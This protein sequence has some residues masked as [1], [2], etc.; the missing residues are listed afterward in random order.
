[1]TR[2]AELASAKR[3]GVRMAATEMAAEGN[4]SPAP[5]SRLQEARGNGRTSGVGRPRLC[6]AELD[7]I[8]SRDRQDTRAGDEQKNGDRAMSGKPGQGPKKSLTEQLAALGNIRPRRLRTR[9]TRRSRPLLLP[10]NIPTSTLQP[11]PSVSSRSCWTCAFLN[12]NRLALGYS[13][14]VSL[15]PS[16]VPRALQLDF[17]GHR[18]TVKAATFCRC[19]GGIF[20]FTRSAGSAR[21]TLG[22][23]PTARNAPYSRFDHRKNSGRTRNAIIL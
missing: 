2:R 5:K 22:S 21:L 15:F 18:V 6:R 12:G 10:R 23:S 20:W 3:S 19:S 13:Y 11:P 17:T 7:D 14:L 9:G 8:G 4:L 16:T 1:M